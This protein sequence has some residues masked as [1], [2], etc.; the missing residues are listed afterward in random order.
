M[1]R[2]V[3]VFIAVAITILYGVG[4]GVSGD[5]RSVVAPVGAVLVALAWVAAWRFGRTDGR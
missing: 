2:N 1:D 5:A 3:L 4:V